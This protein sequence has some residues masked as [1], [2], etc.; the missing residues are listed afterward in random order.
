MSTAL[1]ATAIEALAVAFNASTK[2]ESRKKRFWTTATFLTAGSFTAATIAAC[3]ICALQFAN[4]V[5]FYPIHCITCSIVCAAVAAFLHYQYG[6]NALRPIWN[7]L[8][9]LVD[10]LKTILIKCSLPHPVEA[11]RASTRSQSPQRSE[12]TATCNQGNRRPTEKNSPGACPESNHSRFLPPQIH[13]MTWTA[14]LT[15]LFMHGYLNGLSSNSPGLN[16]WSSTTLG[17]FADFFT[18][19]TTDTLPSH[20][21]NHF[22]VSPSEANATDWNA[23]VIFTSPPSL[24]SRVA[25][26]L[27]STTLWTQQPTPMSNDPNGPVGARATTT[28]TNSAR[29]FPSLRALSRNSPTR[30]NPQSTS[31]PDGALTT[32][33]ADQLHRAVLRMYHSATAAA[34]HTFLANSPRLIAWSAGQRPTLGTAHLAKPGGPWDALAVLW[35]IPAIHVLSLHVAASSPRPRPTVPDVAT[36]TAAAAVML[37][38][39]PTASTTAV[40]IAF[41]AVPHLAAAITNAAYSLAATF[42]SSTRA[43]PL[44]TPAFGGPAS[45]QHDEPRQ[46]DAD[47]I[48]DD[49]RQ[50]DAD[51]ITDETRQDDADAIT[52]E[53]NPFAQP[54]C[55]PRGRSEEEDRKEEE[56]VNNHK[57]HKQ[58]NSKTPSPSP[59]AI[60][61]FWADGIDEAP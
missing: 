61:K 38:F 13:L 53:A 2:L 36:T 1:L 16:W 39:P 40:A 32:Y 46:D 34:I 5:V 48:T 14:T 52:D 37:A 56:S 60:L 25:S 43:E 3:T 57:H 26:A 44:T 45:L 19:S 20:D 31:P 30:P 59:S 55:E 51:V 12:T 4:L 8:A 21:G 35:N 50:D 9:L 22:S 49:A 23:M 47:V 27:A 54:Q 15:L 29:R 18:G 58:E 24:I 11:W 6:I 7:C 42:P 17:Y 10:I 33:I 28:G 41:M